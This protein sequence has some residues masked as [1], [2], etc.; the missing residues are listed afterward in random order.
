MYHP[1]LKGTHF[2]MGQKIGKRFRESHT[3]F[4]IHLDPFQT[5]YGKKSVMLLKEYFPEAIEEMK[6][7]TD[8]IEYDTDLFTAW[9]MCMGCCLDINEN[10]S[11][12]IR[13]CTA[14]SFINQGKVYS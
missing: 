1:R 11:V 4:P 7:V 9:T 12:E 6:G 8:F 13:G 3:I 14:F 10:S 5:D 2:E